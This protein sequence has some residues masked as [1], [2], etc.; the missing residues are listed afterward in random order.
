MPVATVSG[1][2]FHQ[3]F[4][5]NLQGWLEHDPRFLEVVARLAQ[6]DRDQHLR[7]LC[8]KVLLSGTISLPLDR[9][10]VIAEKSIIALHQKKRQDPPN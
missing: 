9:V 2:S 6:V 5:E 7:P 10:G 8:F 3:I 1:A 4:L